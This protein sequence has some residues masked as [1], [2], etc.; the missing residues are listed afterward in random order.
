MIG[1][2][3]SILLIQIIFTVAVIWTRFRL[4]Y[5]S[6]PGFF[7]ELYFTVSAEKSGQIGRRQP[8]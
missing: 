7:I 1:F 5:E 6:R 8:E 4:L 2:I 3:F